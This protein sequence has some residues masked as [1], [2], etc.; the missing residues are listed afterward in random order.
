MDEVVDEFAFELQLE[1]QQDLLQL[2]GR[3][4]PLSQVHFHLLTAQSLL[5][6]EHVLRE[7][8]CHCPVP[9]LLVQQQQMR[10]VF[11]EEFLRKLLRSQVRD[12]QEQQSVDGTGRLH[13]TLHQEVADIHL[14]VVVR[15]LHELDHQLTQLHP[16]WL[17]RTLVLLPD[18]REDL[19]VDHW[20]QMGQK[21]LGLMEVQ[22]LTSPFQGH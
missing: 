7:C 16:H 11:V 12:L 1:L 17:R 2:A 15:D 8:L 4:L 13:Q 21:H 18:Q 10:H 20:L 19:P 9:F 22:E 5:E 14:Q 6:P 3:T